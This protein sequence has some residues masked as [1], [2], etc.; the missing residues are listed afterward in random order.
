MKETQGK[1]SK[2]ELEAGI[3]AAAVEK[4]DLIQCSASLPQFAFL[5][6]SR[7]LTLLHQSL[8]NKMSHGITYSQSPGI[9]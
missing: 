9:F 3:E 7:S 4:A 5:Q 6:N 1:N 2:D 8:I